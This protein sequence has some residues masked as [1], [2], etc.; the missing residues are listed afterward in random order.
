MYVNNV[1]ATPAY[2]YFIPPSMAGQPEEVQKKGEEAPPVAPSWL[3]ISPLEGT[4]EPGECAEVTLWVSAAEVFLEPGK[5]ND[6]LDAILILRIEDGNDAFISVL[7]RLVPSEEAAAAVAAGAEGGTAG[8][9]AAT[10]EGASQA[11]S[12]ADTAVAATAGTT[13]A[14]APLMAGAGPQFADLDSLSAALPAAPAAQ[15][16]DED[17]SLL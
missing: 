10:E 6:L 17:E 12:A 5:G 9:A 1:G 2:W 8:G 7:G 15:K 13:A 16:T 3:K 11:R 14:A 4:I